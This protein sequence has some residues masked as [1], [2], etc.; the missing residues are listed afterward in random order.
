MEYDKEKRE[1]I[2]HR[3]LSEL[4]KFVIDFIKVLEKY[5]DYVII[6]GYVSILLGRTRTTEDVDLFI[7]PI[8]KERLSLLYNELNE[9]G[10]WCINA[11]KLDDIYNY[12][13]SGIAIRFAK[14]GF[15]VPNFEVKFPKDDLAIETYNDIITVIHPLGRLKISSLERHIAFKMYYLGSDKDIEDARHIEKVFKEKLDYN[16]INKL[17]IILEKKRKNGY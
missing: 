6:S 17:R 12:I 10:F 8:T 16:K 3:E 14:K 15:S 5:S 4:D 11:E 7:K 2:L 9:K 1:I 13:S